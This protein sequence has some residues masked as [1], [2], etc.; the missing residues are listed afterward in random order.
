VQGGILR[1]L[2]VAV[3][4]GLLALGGA[5]ALGFDVGDYHGN[6]DGDPI[7]QVAFNVSK[8]HGVRRVTEFTVN[9]V[10]YSCDVG[11][12]TGRSGGMQLLDRMRVKGDGTF[13][14]KGEFTIIEGDPSGRVD[15]RF[16]NGKVKGSFKIRG[17]LAEPGSDCRT[18]EQDWHAEKSPSSP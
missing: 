4:A 2:V 8:K 6:V 3:V 17:E 18:A 14:G 11:P 10:A 15:G 16:V 7:G 9:G 12:P 5:T 13:S 1:R